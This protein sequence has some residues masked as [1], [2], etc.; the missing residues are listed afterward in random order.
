M[1]S[2]DIFPWNENFNTGVPLIDEQ[3]KKLVLLLNQLASHLAFQSD[4]PALNII[5]DELAD[6]AVYH[7]QAEEAIWHEYFPDD[8]LL[9]GHKKVHNS[10][11]ETVYRLKN[12]EPNAPIDRVLEEIISFLARWLASHILENDRYMALVVVAV[13]SGLSLELAKQQAKTQ[14]DGAMRVLVDIILST[15]GSLTTNTLHLMRELAEHKRD[16]ELLRKLSLAVEQSPSSI[17]ITDLDATIEFVNETFLKVTGYSRADIIGKNPKVMQSGKTPKATYKEMWDTLGRGN[18]WKGELF[19]TR[20]DG[21]LMIEQALITPICQPDGKI[22]HYLAIK[23]DITPRKLAEVEMRVAATAFEAQQGMMI[24]DAGKSIVRINKTFSKITG[25]AAEDVIGASPSILSSGRHDANFFEVMWRAVN[26]AG[27]WEGEIWN[28]RKNGEIYP[29]FLSITAVKDKDGVIT[30]YVGAQTDITLLKQHQLEV[31]HIA[32][33]D[34]LTQLPNRR[35]LADRMHQMLSR[36]RRGGELACV[37]CIDLDGFKEVN[38]TLGHEAGDRLLIEVAK[39]ML[40]CVR[41]D[42]TVCRLGGDEFVLLLG[43]LSS[44]DDCEI[45]L[46]R[47]LDELKTPFKLGNSNVVAISGSIGYTLFPEDDADADTLLRHADHAMYVAKQSGKNRFHLFDIKID[48]RTRA[49]WSVLDRIESGLEK[50]E[51]RLFIQPKMSLSSGRIVGAEALIRWQ[52]PIRGVVSPMEFLP[53]IEEHD[54][55]LKI[56]E[57]VMREGVRL[58]DMWGKQGLILPLSVNVGARQLREKDFSVKLGGIL[59][60][61]PAVRPGSLELEVVESAALD[62][63]QLVSMLISE[64]QDYGVC[65]SLDDFGTGYSSL[66]YLKRLAVNTLKIDQTFV[67]DMLADESALAIVRGVISLAQAFQIH[68]VAEGVETWQQATLLKSLGCEIIQGYVVARP[69]PAEEILQWVEKFRVP[70]L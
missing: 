26:S 27:A 63:I 62:D 9:A 8:D 48:N 58:L 34:A 64:C 7:F 43:G 23:E 5:F 47:V 56:G 31:E 42:D 32:Y 50:G 65:F 3:H 35:M 41:N 53:L 49:N 24:T 44:Q 28:R 45:T 40:G 18:V 11:I 10:F 19:N 51:F 16:L 61:Y 30:N 15:Y 39:R 21:T 17:L 1:S 14:L 37:V 70:E 36:A 6:Y 38:D 69:M 29:A 68:T 46:S 52:H 20:K 66:T 12:E 22:T 60:A 57:W 33:H 67:R 2:I 54:L 55:A 4:I 59:K 25:Y 13:Q